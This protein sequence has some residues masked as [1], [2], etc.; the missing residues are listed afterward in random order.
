MIEKQKL[1]K[2][3]N[4]YFDPEEIEAS[5]SFK[6]AIADTLNQSIIDRMKWIISEDLWISFDEEKVGDIKIFLDT[7]NG[8]EN[9][10]SLAELVNRVVELVEHTEYRN[11]L[12]NEFERLA[13]VLRHV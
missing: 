6:A 8:V 2:L 11:A 12:A 9:T 10:I 7:E 1:N 3:G 13:K 5:D 4:A